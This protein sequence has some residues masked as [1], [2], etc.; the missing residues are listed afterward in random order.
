[1]IA[2]GEDGGGPGVVLVLELFALPDPLL[3]AGLPVPRALAGPAVVRGDA[4]VNHDVLEGQRRG[5]IAVAPHLENRHV[6]EWGEFRVRQIR[7][8]SHR[9]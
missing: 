5:G 1:M 3:D 2:V 7:Q 6:E 4:L 8:S 9:T